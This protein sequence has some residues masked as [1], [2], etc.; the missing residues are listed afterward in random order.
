VTTDEALL[1]L[2]ESTGDAVA[3]VLRMFCADAVE[4]SRPSVIPTGT[5]PL[6]GI[7]LPAVAAS[8]SYVDGVTG[9]NIFVTTRRGVQRLAAAMMGMDPDESAEAEELSELELSAVGE[10]MNQMMAAAAAATST[11]LGQGVEIGPPESRFFATP[12]EAGDAYEVTPHMNSVPFTV[13]GEPGRLVQLVPNAFIVRMTRALEDLEAETAAGTAAGGS[14]GGVPT[15]TLRQVPVRVWAELGRARMPIG[16]AVG[17]PPGAVVDLDSAP[18]D[19]VE[20]YVNG[21]HLGSGRLLLIDNEWAVRVDEILPA[22]GDAPALQPG[23][24]D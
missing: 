16:A 12:D 20:L 9:G 6:Q 15:E 7:P 21:R 18:D 23:G 10:A 24:T 8:V 17:L 4:R 3:D 13:L 5:L 2:G 19:P 1:K 14:D 11:V 22:P